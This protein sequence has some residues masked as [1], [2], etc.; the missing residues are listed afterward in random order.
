MSIP[1]WDARPSRQLYRSGT[2][3]Q[4]E[5]TW[6]G[7]S[8]SPPEVQP[9]GVHRQPRR[10]LVSLH[11]QN[12]KTLRKKWRL[13]KQSVQRSAPYWLPLGHVDRR[14]TCSFLHPP[15]YREE[16]TPWPVVGGSPVRCDST[17]TSAQSIVKLGPESDLNGPG[18]LAR[19]TKLPADDTASPTRKMSSLHSGTA[20]KRCGWVATSHWITSSARRSVL[21]LA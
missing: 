20:K 17:A 3:K 12:S 5:S 10:D 19:M 21:L 9:C 14:A 13:K 1:W 18:A 8:L 16:E 15:S 2:S 4:T 7:E 6:I 11:A